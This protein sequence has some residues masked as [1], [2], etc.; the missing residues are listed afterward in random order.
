[1]IIK[2]TKQNTQS[3]IFAISYVAVSLSEYGN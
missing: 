3:T 2:K 1:M